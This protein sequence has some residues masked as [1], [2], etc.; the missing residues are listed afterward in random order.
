M[1]LRCALNE[2]EILGGL[3]D[4]ITLSPSLDE[5]YEGHFLRMTKSEHSQALTFAIYCMTISPSIIEDTYF[6]LIELSQAENVSD[7]IKS[8]LS[9]WVRQGLIEKISEGPL[10]YLRTYHRTYREFL[11]NRRSDDFGETG[12]EQNLVQAIRDRSENLFSSIGA[13]ARARSVFSS[14]LDLILKLSMASQEYYMIEGVLSDPQVWRNCNYLD[15]GHD[16][17]FRNIS[18][19]KV[20][21]GEN[22]IEAEFFTRIA[23]NIVRMI[24]DGILL[25]RYGNPL[26]RI[27]ILD[28]VYQSR[29]T[30]ESGHLHFVEFLIEALEEAPKYE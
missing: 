24:D 27:R 28:M 19:M 8:A 18:S 17:I 16:L 25:E 26:T 30:S 9:E 15:Q 3:G 12:F 11:G 29:D 2:S 23:A 14:K 22:N 5:Y 4:K 6:Y 13:S 20:D 10:R 21:A 7:M 1:I